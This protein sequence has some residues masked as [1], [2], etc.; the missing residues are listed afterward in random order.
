M[1]WKFDAECGGEN[2]DLFFSDHPGDIVRAK[3]ICTECP[4]KAECLANSEPYGIWGGLTRNER[5]KL[6][7]KP[8]FTIEIRERIDV[9]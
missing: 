8:K 2:L 5:I 4:V 7:H 1:S 9:A 6:R 3:A